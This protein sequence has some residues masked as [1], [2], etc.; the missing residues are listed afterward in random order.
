KAHILAAAGGFN[1]YAEPVFSINVQ[2]DEAL[3]GAVIYR[4][5]H[6]ILLGD[7]V[8]SDIGTLYH[9]LFK[10]VGDTWLCDEFPVFW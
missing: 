5:Q 10:K 4:I 1:A 6:D 3:M 9:F 2:G 8:K 7:S